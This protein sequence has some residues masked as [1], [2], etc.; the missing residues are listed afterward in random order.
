MHLG[1]ARFRRTRFRVSSPAIDNLPSEIR[2]HFSELK[3]KDVMFQ[4]NSPRLGSIRPADS[5]PRGVSKLWCRTD[6]RRQILKETQGLQKTP[7]TEANIQ[8]EDDIAGNIRREYGEAKVLV[9]EKIDIADRT[10]ALVCLVWRE[11]FTFKRT[12]RPAFGHGNNWVS[13][14]LSVGIPYSATGHGIGADAV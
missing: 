1:T 13:C 8:K 12:R 11:L 2:H 14:S 9:D 7:A 10:L 6:L 5:K 3:E 4:G